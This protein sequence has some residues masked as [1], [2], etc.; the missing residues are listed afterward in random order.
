MARR[1]RDADKLAR[2]RRLAASGEGRAIREAHDLSLRELAAEIPG[3]R[4]KTVTPSSVMKWER[5]LSRPGRVA[6]LR[7]LEVLEGLGEQ[8]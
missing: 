4:G 8:L 2:A 7:Y 6:A 1:Q 3:R 5:G